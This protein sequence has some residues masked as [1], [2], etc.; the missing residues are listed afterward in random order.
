MTDAYAFTDLSNVYVALS[1]S[2]GR[3]TI[4]LLRA[5][6]PQVVLQGLNEHLQIEDGRLQK[7]DVV[8]LN[9]TTPVLT[10]S[11]ENC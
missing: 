7:L 1:R 10:G 11:P 6:E 9:Q 5:F 2:S 3:D 8:T 4:R